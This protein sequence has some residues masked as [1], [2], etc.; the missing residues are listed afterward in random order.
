MA[1]R[2]E[3]GPTYVSGTA[4]SSSLYHGTACAT[5]HDDTENASADSGTV[6]AP[7]GQRPATKTVTLWSRA[8]HNDHRQL[9]EAISQEMAGGRGVGG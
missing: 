2:R 5:P 7:A 9:L 4:I 6:Q 1:R 8:P 3:A